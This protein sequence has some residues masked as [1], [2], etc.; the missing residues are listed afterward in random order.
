[1][2]AHAVQFRFILDEHAIVSYVPDVHISHVLQLQ[3]VS[4]YV[5]GAHDNKLQN[6]HVLCIMVSSNSVIRNENDAV[7]NI[8]GVIATFT[9]AE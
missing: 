8:C 2:G 5:P 1:M 9:D 3:D 6:G 4:S 7:A